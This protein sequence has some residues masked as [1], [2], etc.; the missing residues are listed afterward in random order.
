MKMMRPELPFDHL[1]CYSLSAEKASTYIRIEMI[2]PILD[3][4][5]QT[6]RGPVY[7]RIVDQNVDM[8]EFRFDRGDLLVNLLRVA[9]IQFD[10]ETRR[11]AVR[12]QIHRFVKTHAGLIGNSNL[13]TCPRQHHGDGLSQSRCRAGYQGRSISEFEHVSCSLL[14]DLLKLTAITIA[15]IANSAACGRL[16]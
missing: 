1:G 16:P 14:V 2:V 8:A 11:A 4:H 9:D 15:V 12:T 5:L 13:C 10:C 3:V 6:G 7:S